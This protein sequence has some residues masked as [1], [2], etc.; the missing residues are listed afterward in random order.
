[1][2]TDQIDYQQ[3]WKHVQ[4]ITTMTGKGDSKNVCQ[5]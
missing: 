1:M 2:P 5:H 3:E 4:N